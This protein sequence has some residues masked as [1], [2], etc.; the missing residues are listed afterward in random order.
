MDRLMKS[1]GFHFSIPVF[2]LSSREA[3]NPIY[4]VDVWV[5]VPGQDEF[6]KIPVKDG[7]SDIRVSKSHVYF[8]HDGSVFWLR[9]GYEK[10]AAGPDSPVITLLKWRTVK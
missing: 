6:Q 1:F 4:L 9:A 2:A 8:D 7:K 10:S 3:E 5:L